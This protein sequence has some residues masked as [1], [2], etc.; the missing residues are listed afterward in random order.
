[1]SY[2]GKKSETFGNFEFNCIDLRQPVKLVV[3]EYTKVFSII[4]FFE[5]LTIES[6][7]YFN[8]FLIIEYNEFRFT[9]IKA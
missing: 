5:G 6:Y 3:Y 2:F 9:D 4:N 7:I 1:M 8:L